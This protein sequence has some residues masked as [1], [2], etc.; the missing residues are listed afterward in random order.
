MLQPPGNLHNAL[1]EMTISPR[2]VFNLKK[3]HFVHESGSIVDW[4]TRLPNKA[5]S[6]LK[7]RRRHKSL[8]GFCQEAQK[9]ATSKLLEYLSLG[10]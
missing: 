8:V 5:R 6:H 4:F 10:A 9:S 3:C 2:L 1:L 7:T